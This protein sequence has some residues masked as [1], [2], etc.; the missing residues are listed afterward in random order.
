VLSSDAVVALPGSTGTLSEIAYAL[1]YGRPVLLLGWR[2][3]PLAGLDL[4]RL[5]TVEETVAALRELL[6]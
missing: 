3:Q 2:M 5:E 4:P 1:S 6:A